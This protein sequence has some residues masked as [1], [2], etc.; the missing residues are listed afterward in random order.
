MD[1]KKSIRTHFNVVLIALYVVSL[2]ITVPSVY[3]FTRQ[4]VYDNASQKLTLLVDMVT[5]LRK[6]VSDDV[7][8]ELLEKNVLFPPAISSTVATGHVAAYFK[9][10]QPD[11]YIR[12]VSDNPLNAANR[13]EAV[14]QEFLTFFR[15]NRNEKELIS[16]GV[17]RNQQY[18]FSSRPS[19]SKADC[20]ICHSTPEAAPEIIRKEYGTQSG[21]GYKLD[22]VVGASVVGVPLSD[23]QSLVMKRSLIA[24]GILTVLFALIFV[25]INLVVKRRILNPLETIAATADIISKGNLDTPLTFE[26]DDEIGKLAHSIELMRRSLAKIMERMSRK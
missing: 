1:M 14:E 5:S 26:R 25:V 15:D 7:R 17:V 23:V 4:E 11:Y 24:I 16:T 12:V 10:L 18:L 9:K 2:L 8:P 22:S 6:Y 3:F 13:P 21:F 19:I 20:M